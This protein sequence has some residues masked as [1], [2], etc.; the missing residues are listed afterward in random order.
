M[1]ASLAQEIEWI[2]NEAEVDYIDLWHLIL[3]ANEAEDA[4]P[5]LS[6]MERTL[7]LLGR[8][9]DRGFL[10]VD[11]AEEGKCVPWPDQR[12]AAILGRIERDWRRLDNEPHIGAITWFQ[13][14][15]AGA[16][17]A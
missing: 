2:I 13:L 1:A 4:D 10:A 3:A 9:L 5:K 14:P 17:E 8:L 16:T 11:L 6:R 7:A 12:R 15:K